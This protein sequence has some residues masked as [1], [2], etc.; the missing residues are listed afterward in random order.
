PAARADSSGGAS[1]RDCAWPPGGK[2]SAAHSR[3]ANDD[4]TR[5]DKDLAA[6]A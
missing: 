5:M 2:A 6:A 1:P 3:T 4:L